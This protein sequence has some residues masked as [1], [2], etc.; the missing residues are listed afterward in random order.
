[1]NWYNEWSEDQQVAREEQ[2]VAHKTEVSDALT[3][4]LGPAEYRASN[5]NVMS[6]LSAHF[7]K[8]T[9]AAL[10]SARGPDGRALFNTLGFVK[11]M[12]G[13]SRLVNPMATLIG[14]GASDG[15][16]IEAELETINAER[17]KDYNAFMKNDKLR[18]R[19]RELIEL[20]ASVAARK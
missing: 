5:N 14:A 2:D 6:M 10:M 11:G 20:K 7:D 15:K 13:L 8:D 4:E 17:N 1:V 9:V 3:T 12:F 19:E 16:S 18:A